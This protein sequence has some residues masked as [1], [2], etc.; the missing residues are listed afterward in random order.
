MDRDVLI[1]TRDRAEARNALSSPASLIDNDS[2]GIEFRG[3][4]PSTK[5]GEDLQGTKATTDRDLFQLLPSPYPYGA[6]TEASSPLAD[7]PWA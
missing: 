7:H 4:V 5:L 3:S 6:T 2:L 1:E